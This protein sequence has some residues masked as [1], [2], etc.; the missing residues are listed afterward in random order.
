MTN[1][2][3]RRTAGVEEGLRRPV[4]RRKPG[5][6]D[7]RIGFLFLLPLFAGLLVFRFYGFGYN[8]WLSFNKAGAFGRARFTGLENYER[9]FSDSQLRISLVNTFK[10]TAIVVPGVVVVALLCATLMQ[11][12]FRGQSAFR[13]IVFLPAVCLPTAAILLFGWLFQTRYG[14]VNAVIQAVGGSS[15]SWFG[16]S[17]GVTVV[18]TVIVVF[19]SFSVPTI[20]LY[21][22]MQEIP[23]DI[24]E[25]ATLDGAGPVRR[26]F[27]LTLPL[28]SPSLFFVILTTTISTLKLFDVAYVLLPPEQ[29]ASVNY[30]LTAVYYYY[31]LA[32]LN[33]GDRGYASAVSLLLFVLILAVSIVLFRLQRRFVHYGEDG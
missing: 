26:Y 24:Y 29:S 33:V 15:V 4:V 5:R 1:V 18:I 31:Q 3:L 6:R 22:G 32:F 28:L 20:I 2:T 25:S 9:L 12:K 14:L 8:V 13:A 16:S 27:S 19:L 21:A 23:S 7:A 11:Y 10:F 17:A 30:G